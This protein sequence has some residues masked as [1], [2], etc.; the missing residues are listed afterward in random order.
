MSELRIK[1]NETAELVVTARESDSYTG[2]ALFKLEKQYA[3]GSKHD[4]HE[5]FTSPVM[6]EQIGRFLIKEAES[7]RLVQQSRDKS[8]RV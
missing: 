5:A 3:D 4:A 8:F 7:I 6:L 1:L 2:T